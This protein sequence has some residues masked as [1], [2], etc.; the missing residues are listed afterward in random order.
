MPYV[1]A[2]VLGALVLLVSV[3][4]LAVFFYRQR[5]ATEIKYQALRTDAGA[6]D[7]AL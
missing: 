6:D 3:G 5:R 4:G 2:I 7:E 1:A